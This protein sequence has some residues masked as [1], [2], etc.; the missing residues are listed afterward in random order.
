MKKLKSLLKDERGSILP[1][2]VGIIFIALA[3][4]AVVVDFGRYS[5]TKEKL[6]T[7]GD[8]A[9]LAGAKT[10]YRYVKLE[11][12]PGSQRECCGEE[13]CSPCCVDC[14]DP[15]TVSGREAYLLDNDGWEKYCCN[16]GCRYMKILDRWVEYDNHSDV[17]A[18]TNTLFQINQ[19]E[20]MDALEGGNADIAID[21]RGDRKDPLYPS[22]IVKAQGTM[23][24]VMMDIFKIFDPSADF[25]TMDASTCSQ[26]ATYVKDVKNGRWSRPPSS[27]CSE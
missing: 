15:F 20:E 26:G 4:L 25:S 1:I 18:A 21:I 22:V 10:G 8:A 9:A 13:E 19:P 7:A 14:G 23:K 3:L 27:S 6:Q 16:C 11:I 24:T 2:T 17:V 5:M 12:D